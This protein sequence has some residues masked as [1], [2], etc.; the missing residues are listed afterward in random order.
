MFVLSLV[1]FFSQIE[2]VR[3]YFFFTGS[4]RKRVVSSLFYGCS[5]FRCRLPILSRV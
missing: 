3:K 4:S 2:Y 5:I 1:R